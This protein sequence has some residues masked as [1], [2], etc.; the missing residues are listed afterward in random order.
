M[1]KKTKE[2]ERRE[3]RTNIFRKAGEKKRK[4]KGGKRTRMILLQKRGLNYME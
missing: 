3:K 1:F 2:D 4:M